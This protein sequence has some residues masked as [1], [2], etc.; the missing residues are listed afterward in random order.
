MK[1]ER[2]IEPRYYSY[3][4]A[5]ATQRSIAGY[6]KEG[7]MVVR[8]ECLRRLGDIILHLPTSA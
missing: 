8:R 3:V 6:V 1:Q 2:K 7:A 4:Y 5:T